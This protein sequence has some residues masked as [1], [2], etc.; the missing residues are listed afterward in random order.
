MQCVAKTAVNLEVLL[1]LGEFAKLLPVFLS[2]LPF[3]V[4]D[5]SRYALRHGVPWLPHLVVCCAP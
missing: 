5:R 4:W 2:F 3:E 1:F